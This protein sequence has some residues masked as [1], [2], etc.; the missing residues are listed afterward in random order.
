MEIIVILAHPNKQ[1]FNH[2]IAYKIVSSLKNNN[3]KV[4]F[5]DL[6]DEDFNPSIPYEEI[7]KNGRIDSKIINYC[8]ELKTCNGII[9]VHPNWWGQPPAILKGW[10]DRVII[11]GV[12]YKFNENDKGEGIPSG[13]LTG[14][15]A[16]VFNTTDTEYKREME[17]FGDPLDTIWKN[18]IFGFCGI[19]DYFRKVFGII[20]TSTDSERKKW[21][22]ETGEI[23]NKFFP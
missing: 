12:A 17:V 3:H 10:I 16:V 11:P 2:A 19:E 9:F 1:S 21:L 4:I 8:N 6:Y 20:V 22:F 23:I 7:R 5:H 15:K 18:C 14:I 13:L